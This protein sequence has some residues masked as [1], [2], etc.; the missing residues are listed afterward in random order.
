MVPAVVW[1]V[2]LVWAVLDAIY[3][4]QHANTTTAD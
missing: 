1:S 4:H 3:G 2:L